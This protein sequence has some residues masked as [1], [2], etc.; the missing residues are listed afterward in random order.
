MRIGELIRQNCSDSESSQHYL[1]VCCESQHQGAK[2]AG[3]RIPPSQI[4]TFSSLLPLKCRHTTRATIEIKIEFVYQRK[5]SVNFLDFQLPMC[6]NT[7]FA[8]KIKQNYSLLSWLETVQLRTGICYPMLLDTPKSKSHSFLASDSVYGNKTY[9][10]HMNFSQ[11][12]SLKE[13]V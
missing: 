3:N 7:L 1:S 10:V 2:F 5:F 13:I 9:Y 6:A 11:L 8:K 4:N 12:A